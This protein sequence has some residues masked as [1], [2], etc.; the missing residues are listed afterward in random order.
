M[1]AW[2]KQVN[3][4]SHSRYRVAY[5]SK[6]LGGDGNYLPPQINANRYIEILDNFLI[7]S[8]ENCLRYG[9]VIFKMRIHFVTEKKGLRFSSGKLYKII[10]MASEQ[11]GFKSNCKFMVEI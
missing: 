6:A 1:S 4:P 2:R 11:S 9:E 7:P 5:H 3:F 8:I 10:D